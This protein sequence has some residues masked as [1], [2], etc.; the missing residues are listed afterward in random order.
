MYIR[1]YVF[2]LVLNVFTYVIYIMAELPATLASVPIDQQVPYL[3]IYIPD[4]SL[5]YIGDFRMYVCVFA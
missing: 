3:S 1:M 4:L 5:L 2:V